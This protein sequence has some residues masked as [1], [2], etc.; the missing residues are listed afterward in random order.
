MSGWFWGKSLEIIIL[1]L[2]LF[3]FRFPECAIPSNE[4]RDFET[5]LVLKLSLH[6]AG[7]NQPQP[8]KSWKYMV[9]GSAV[10]DSS[11]S[12]FEPVEFTFAY[13][14][15]HGLYLWRGLQWWVFGTRSLNNMKL[16]LTEMHKFK[17]FSASYRLL[18]GFSLI[19]DLSVS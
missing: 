1:R 13:V 12:R 18:E 9:C 19:K 10:S 7:V 5:R 15:H 6:P 4:L 2:G 14:W 11:C 8:Q 16:V 3:I 17:L